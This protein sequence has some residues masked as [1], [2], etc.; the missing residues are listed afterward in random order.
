MKPC[1]RSAAAVAAAILSVGLVSCDSEPSDS[2]AG[3]TP[4]STTSD[5]AARADFTGVW[6]GYLT[7][8][9]HPFWQFEDVSCFPGCPA[10]IRE[11]MTAALDDPTNSGRI[12]E[13]QAEVRAF[14][15]QYTAGL[16][17]PDGLARLQ[18]SAA[19]AAAL[20]TYCEPY[21]LLREAMNP[22]PFRIRDEG[23]RLIFEYE[24]WRLTRTIHLDGG[25]RPPEVATPMGFSVGRYEGGALV[26]ESTAFTGDYY[27]GRRGSFSD[28]AKIVERYV[29]HEEPRRLVLELTI[30]D[31]VTLTAPYVWTKTWLYTPDVELVRDS[32]E[33][34]AGQL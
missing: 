16:M 7:T 18:A 10:A 3:N 5:T 34:V 27:P 21:G 32:C 4:S 31:P 12:A 1:C 33:D 28:A 11:R 30:T 2:A 26:V 17:T 24:E 23:G 22:L 19:A 6:S 14:G 20:D 25:G 15:D 9:S 8:D 29:I 13:V